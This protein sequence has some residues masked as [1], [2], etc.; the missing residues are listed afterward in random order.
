VGWL[1]ARIAE[2]YLLDNASV[3]VSFLCVYD[4]STTDTAKRPLV[5]TTAYTSYLS[6]Y[7][8]DYA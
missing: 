4:Q 6:C 2:I 7:M 1:H 5:H 3:T 8:S